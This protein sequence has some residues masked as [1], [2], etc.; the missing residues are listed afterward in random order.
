MES[1]YISRAFLLSPFYKQISAL[2]ILQ[3]MGRKKNYQCGTRKTNWM[4]NTSLPV[5]PYPSL[6]WLFKNRSLIILQLFGNFWTV[7]WWRQNSFIAAWSMKSTRHLGQ[8]FFKV[9]PA[10][11]GLNTHHL[12]A[13]SQSDFLFFNTIYQLEFYKREIIFFDLWTAGQTF[14]SKFREQ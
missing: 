11:W 14:Q 1:L 13:S 8:L 6:T 12:T 3:N 2:L 4:S 7:N 10:T 9:T 5:F